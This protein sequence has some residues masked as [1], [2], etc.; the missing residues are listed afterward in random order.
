MLCEYGCGQEATHQFKNGKWCCNNHITKCSINKE[1]IRNK[2]IGRKL[3]KNHI[4]KLSKSHIG[5][6]P[7]KKTRK[8]IS[9]SI[10]GKNHPN[11]GKTFSINTIKKMS[12]SHIGQRKRTI[13]YLKAL[14]SY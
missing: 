9:D 5:I 12:K 4:K 7:T 11:Y 2:L 13:K 10:K 1:K 6:K 8:K 3:S 14:L